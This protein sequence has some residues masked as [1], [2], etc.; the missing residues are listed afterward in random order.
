[1]IIFFIKRL[2]ERQVKTN[3]P[4]KKYYSIKSTKEE[5]TAMSHTDVFSIYSF[6]GSAFDSNPFF[7]SAF[8]NG[9]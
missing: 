9:Q 3:H 6:N 7:F 8:N 2:Y 1:M 4:R 5:G